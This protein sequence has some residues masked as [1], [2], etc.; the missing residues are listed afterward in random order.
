MWGFSLMNALWRN[1]DE[2]RH[3]GRFQARRRNLGRGGRAF[4]VGQA[5]FACRSRLEEA[6][7]WVCCERL[8]CQ[9]RH[10]S[11]RRPF[12]GPAGATW[13]KS[14]FL[15][16]AVAEHYKPQNTHGKKSGKISDP[17]PTSNSQLP[18]V[19]PRTTRLF[20]R[21]ATCAPKHQKPTKKNA[22]A[23]RDSNP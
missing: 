9:N 21:A 16:P 6:W 14:M 8:S 1:G 15:T 12:W 7:E 23:Q 20:A 11:L 18:P 3:F 22:R 10:F 4:W 13:P 17:R 19:R 2:N 5:E